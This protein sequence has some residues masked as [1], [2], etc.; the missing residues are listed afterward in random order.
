MQLRGWLCSFL[1][2]LF[3][4]Y[5]LRKYQPVHMG[6]KNNHNKFKMAPIIKYCM[7]LFQKFRRGNANHSL[8]EETLS[9]FNMSSHFHPNHWF[10]YLYQ[11]KENNIP[12]DWYINSI[13]PFPPFGRHKVKITTNS[14]EHLQPNKCIIYKQW[15]LIDI[16]TK[17]LTLRNCFL[18][19]G[20]FQRCQ[21]HH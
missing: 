18:C 5:F 12:T 17:L 4:F 21:P 15:S 9:M 20:F 1:F 19:G 3:L 6:V 2:L 16:N 10:S 8:S 13:H 14:M 7:K 11:F